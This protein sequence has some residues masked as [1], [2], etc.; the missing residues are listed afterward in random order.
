MA[1]VI[2]GYLTE[3]KLAAALK[4]IVGDLWAADQVRLPRITAEVGYGLQAE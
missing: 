4:Q 1:I 2:E 3:T